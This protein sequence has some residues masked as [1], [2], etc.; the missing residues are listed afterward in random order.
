L[1]H[2][3]IASLALATTRWHHASAFNVAARHVFRF[4]LIPRGG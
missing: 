2:D 4:D 3:W 1:P